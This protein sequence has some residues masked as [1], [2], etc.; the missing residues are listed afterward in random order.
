VNFLHDPLA[1]AVAL[2]WNGV[3]IDAIPLRCQ[4]RD[5]F[6]SLSRD[7]AAAT[8]DEVTSVDG[9]GFND[10]WLRTVTAAGPGIQ[11]AAVV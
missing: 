9:S 1:C 5:G 10:V 11:G 8:I 6:L 2:G 4:E 3:N 7:P